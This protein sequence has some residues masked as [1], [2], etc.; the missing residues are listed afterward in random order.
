[1]QGDR[2]WGQQEELWLATKKPQNE[3]ALCIHHLFIPLSKY[4]SSYI[5]QA[6]DD[7]Y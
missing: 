7:S 4:P 3:L 2:I 6:L 5:F 1:M